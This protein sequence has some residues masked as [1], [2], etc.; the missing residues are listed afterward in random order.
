MKKILSGMFF[1]LV[2]GYEIWALLALFLFAVTYLSYTDV[3]ELNYLSAKYVPG[4]TYSYD[5]DNVETVICKD[6]AEQLCFKNSGISA[7]DLYRSSVEKIPQEEYDKLSNEMHD[8]P[9]YEMETLYLEIQRSFFIPAVLMAIFI[10]VFFG[11]LF[12]DGTIKNIVACGYSKGKIYLAS[13]VMTAIL[14]LAMILLSLIIL[15]GICICLKWQPPVYLPVLI[16]A[17]FISFLLLL[18]ITS[19]CLA[20]LFAGGKKTVAF[21]VGFVMV[22]AR[23]FPASIFSTGLLW[24]GQ[25]HNSIS[26][27]SDDTIA[28]L[29]EVGRNGLEE[30]IDLSQFIEKYYVN[31]EEIEYIWKL[32]NTHPPVVKASLLT[33]IYLDPYLVDAAKLYSYGFSPYLMY[34][35]GVMAINITSNIFWIGITNGLALLAVRK[36]ELHC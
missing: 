12:S 24:L 27:I 15:A 11:R 2:R 1:R 36:R 20:A 14:D 5:Y 29:K 23:F 33:L 6:N 28:L 17:A 32:E 8:N 26:E 22:A 3:M 31:G 4:Y 9:Y 19:V 21:V 10:P 34:R 35:D 25:S 13:L 18:L 7:F 16:T 30:R